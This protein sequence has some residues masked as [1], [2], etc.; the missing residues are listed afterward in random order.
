MDAT[1]I[2]PRGTEPFGHLLADRAGVRNP[3]WGHDAHL[4]DRFNRISRNAIPTGVPAFG[5]WTTDGS[6]TVACTVELREAREGRAAG[7]VKSPIPGVDG[8]T[9][10]VVSLDRLLEPSGRESEDGL[11][12]RRNPA[13]RSAVGVRRIRIGDEGR[14]GPS[15]RAGTDRPTRD[16]RPGSSGSI[17]GIT[18]EFREKGNARDAEGLTSATARSIVRARPR[19]LP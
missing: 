5:K 7:R 8:P 3:P 15:S 1:L 6:K 4:D 19:A 12:G 16:S 11:P 17:E 10:R 14:T 18:A 9:E 13:K 2:G